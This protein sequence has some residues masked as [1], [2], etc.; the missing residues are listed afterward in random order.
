MFKCWSNLENCGKKEFKVHL[1]SLQAMVTCGCKSNLPTLISNKL[2]LCSQQS[3]LLTT[4]TSV[5]GSTR[6][7]STLHQG[8]C[9]SRVCVHVKPTS[10]IVLLF[11]STALLLTPP[12]VVLVCFVGFRN[13]RFSWKKDEKSRNK[14]AKIQKRGLSIVHHLF[15]RIQ[16]DMC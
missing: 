13:A 10:Y 9:S 16:Y 11:P 15:Q 4:Y 6:P 2:K 8:L 12:H 1:K 7:R 3:P 14:F 5:T